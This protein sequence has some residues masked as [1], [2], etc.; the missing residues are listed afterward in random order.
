MNMLEV[1][2]NYTG[3]Y[4]N[5][6]NYDIGVMEN[7]ATNSGPPQYF[8]GSQPPI[9][10][11]QNTEM[12]LV[13]DTNAARY[14]PA[15][16]Y[17]TFYDKLVIVPATALTPPSKRGLSE[18][19]H[20]G[21]LDF[22]PVRRGVAQPSETPWFCYWNHTM[23]ETFIYP[24][25]SSSNVATTTTSAAAS[26]ATATGVVLQQF[27]PPYPKII[28]VEERRLPRIQSRPY[29]QKMLI[30]DDGWAAP[31]IDPTTNQI[32]TFQ[33]NETEST[34]MSSSGSKRSV[35]LFGRDSSDDSSCNCVWLAS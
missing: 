15:W 24:N 22:T 23:L 18:R 25:A 33:L 4:N 35:R 9:I 3:S 30:L 31:Y 20:F 11:G 13:N 8:Y 6:T 27:S 2:V 21:M 28:R 34:Y 17:Q 19:V 7:S 5:L 12:T 32:V 16:F 1:T 26:T 29:C 10:T 14:G